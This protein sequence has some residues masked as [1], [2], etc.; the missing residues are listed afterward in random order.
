MSGAD[1]STFSTDVAVPGA[2]THPKTASHPSRAEKTYEKFLLG[3]FKGK[4]KRGDCFDCSR[5]KHLTMDCD[6]KHEPKVA[7]KIDVAVV[8]MRENNKL[9]SQKR[10]C[11]K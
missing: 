7:S 10:D 11:A 5:Y 6:R 4:I 2:V 9:R 1:A 3:P 8:K